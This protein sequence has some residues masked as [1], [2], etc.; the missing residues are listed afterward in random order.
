[1]KHEKERKDNKK[2]VKDEF[3]VK[4][5]DNESIKRKKEN[6]KV[7][8]KIDSVIDKE[9]VEDVDKDKVKDKDASLDA[10]AKS[11]K[12]FRE[13]KKPKPVEI[14]ETPVIYTKEMFQHNQCKVGEQLPFTCDRCFISKTS[15]N[16]YIY[17]QKQRTI[18]NGCYALL[19]A[20]G[21]EE[22]KKAQGNIEN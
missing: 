3:R 17:T 20:K 2:S 16:K 21:K 7:E 11:R 13:S 15:R 9:I 5:N 19:I 18:C 4:L 10:V 6:K 14:D 1:M 12:G 8:N 22:N